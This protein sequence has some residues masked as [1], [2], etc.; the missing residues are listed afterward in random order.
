[1]LAPLLLVGCSLSARRAGF[2]GTEGAFES[3]REQLLR[4]PEEERGI[5]AERQGAGAV[6]GVVEELSK[7]DNIDRISVA[8]E[9]GLSSALRGL[10]SP[11]MAEGTGGSGSAVGEASAAVGAG[12][13]RGFTGECNAEPFQCLRA[14]TRELGGEFG[15]GMAAKLWENVRWPLL[16]LVFL[17]GAL[18]G[19]LVPRLVNRRRDLGAH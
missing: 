14:R 15:A 12:L 8:I 5:I 16:A 18:T 2:R 3:A 4:I 13:V 19:G 11:P 6:R 1:V 17:L 10:S 9:G 7:G